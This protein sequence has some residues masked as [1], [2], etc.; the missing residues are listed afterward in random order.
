MDSPGYANL[1][2]E[3]LLALV[4]FTGDVFEKS[5]S[6]GIDGKRCVGSAARLHDN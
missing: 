1:V 3:L 4:G 2:E 6:S 5:H